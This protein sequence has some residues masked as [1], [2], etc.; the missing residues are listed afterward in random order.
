MTKNIF[1]TALVVFGAG[2]LMAGCDFEQPE[3]GC[4]VQD[5][6]NWYAKYDIVQQPTPVDATVSCA[7]ARPLIGERL[8]VY[9]FVNPDAND[10]TQLTIRPAGLAGLGDRDDVNPSTA[11]TAIGEMAK[12]PDGEEFCG[13]PTFTAAT[14]DAARVPP[15]EDDPATE[16][17]ES[18]PAIAAT[19]VTY[20]FSK[21]RVYSAPATPGTQLTGELRYTKDGCVST[22]I[23]RAM[24]PAALCIPG[25]AD[26]AESC[27]LGS[28]L[29]PDFA[30]ECFPTLQ[31]CGLTP[32]QAAAGV[33]CCVP[34]KAI[35]SFK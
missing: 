10:F 31:N 13:A 25:S 4:I 2:S 1:K 9:K 8:G 30:A 28:G 29:N 22:Y 32:E 6:G 16:E 24:W 7:N 27:G 17:D 21:V 35:P 20:E 18:A 33:A 12:E 34:S 19:K 3:A 14:V 26:P 15:V 11:Q 5:A 23:V